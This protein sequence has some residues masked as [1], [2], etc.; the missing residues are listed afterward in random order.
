MTDD[1]LSRSARVLGGTS[2][3]SA[4][5]EHS[6][7]HAASAAVAPAFLKIDAVGLT[8]IRFADSDQVRVGDYVLAIGNPFGLGKSITAGIV[9]G[10]GRTVS[11]N[12]A[13]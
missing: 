4:E 7:Q 3:A 2:S 1:L 6:L 9:S 5:I 13:P 12:G 11:Q 8:A 10:L